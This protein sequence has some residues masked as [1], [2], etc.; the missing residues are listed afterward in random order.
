MT[1]H[2]KTYLDY[3]DLIDGE[4]WMCE[5]CG[6]S[7]KINN[8]LDIHHILP[9]SRGGKDNIDNLMCLCRRCHDKVHNEGMHVS[10]DTSLL[11]RTK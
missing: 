3:F 2:V 1:N 5:A 10:L 6:H 8:G 11:D 9:R 4:V 7:H